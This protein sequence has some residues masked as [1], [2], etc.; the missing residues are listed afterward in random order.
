M[1][2]PAMGAY[3]IPNKGGGVSEEG[4]SYRYLRD[5]IW[6][7]LLH[8]KWVLLQK[9][10]KRCQNRNISSKINNLHFIFFG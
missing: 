4:R 10:C 3:S 8:S 7:Y 2:P 6:D 1:R 5:S 9:C